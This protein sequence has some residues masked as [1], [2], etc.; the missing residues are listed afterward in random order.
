[1]PE[2]PEVQIMVD[3]LNRIL[4]NNFITVSILKQSSIIKNNININNI[5]V[6]EISRKGKWII[7]E[8]ENNKMLV[9]HLGMT[10]RFSEEANKNNVLDILINTSPIKH[11][12]YSDIRGFGKILELDKISLESY[13]PINAIKVDGL[14]DDIKTIYTRFKELNNNKQ[15]IKPFLLDYR[16]ISG[17]GNIY[18]SEILYAAKINPY[19]K[20]YKLTEEELLT[21]SYETK[22]ILEEAYK[23][24]GSTIESFYDAEGRKG[25]YQ[26]KHNVYGQK[27]CRHCG[28]KVV[29]T[30][31]KGRSTFYCS[32]EQQL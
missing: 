21:I 1:M 2:G 11:L 5:K 17:I 23:N 3:S 4:T 15:E 20:V 19:K 9:I 26:E 29:R 31:Q 22:R 6:E 25:N 14:K 32:N 8:F 12:Y 16:N 24:G 7:I 30:E 13:N 28:S 27:N 18:A 10:G